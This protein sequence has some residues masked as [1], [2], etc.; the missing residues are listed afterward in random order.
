VCRSQKW[1]QKWHSNILIRPNVSTSDSICENHPFLVKTINIF[2]WHNLKEKSS[3]QPTAKKKI[4]NRRDSRYGL[5]FLGLEFSVVSQMFSF[6]F[7]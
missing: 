7:W 1:S 2:I 4:K 5:V 3:A 6:G